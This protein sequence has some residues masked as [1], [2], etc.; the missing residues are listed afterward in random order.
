VLGVFHTMGLAAHTM[1]LAA[2]TMEL[3]ARTIGL[4]AL[5]VKF[6]GL[7][8]LAMC[9]IDTRDTIDTSEVRQ[10]PSWAPGVNSHSASRT[11]LPTPL[12][13]TVAKSAPLAT[14]RKV[15]NHSP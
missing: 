2:H 6:L 11:P 5:L 14:R 10:H 15:A 1:G 13:L 12:E 8:F 4:A 7:G 9:N 3:V